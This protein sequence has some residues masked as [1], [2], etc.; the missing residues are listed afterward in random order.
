MLIFIL[1]S[2]IWA[3]EVDTVVAKVWIIMV[4]SLLITIYSQDVSAS[5]MQ[6]VLHK[7]DGI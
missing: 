1:I 7:L 5:E 3:G 4:R 6:E 2:A